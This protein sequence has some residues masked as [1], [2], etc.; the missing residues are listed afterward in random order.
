M[1]AG[2]SVWAAAG[3]SSPVS[4]PPPFPC[5]ATS[6]ASKASTAAIIAGSVG[7]AWEGGLRLEDEIAW[8]GHDVSGYAVGTAA[9]GTRGYNRV[10][11]DMANLVYD[12]PL[13]DSWKIS[14]GGG[15]GAPASR[16]HIN[17]PRFGP[18]RVNYRQWQPHRP[19]LSGHRR[20]RLFAL[21]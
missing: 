4:R 8:D 14:L 3:I 20:H 12:I 21:R 18:G 13:D 5:R 1:T 15:I 19:R 6:A 2:I 11:T 17:A 10:S 16:I 7:Y 9:A